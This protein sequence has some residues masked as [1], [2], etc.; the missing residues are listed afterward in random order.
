MPP[1]RN[2]DMMKEQRWR[3]TFAKWEASGLTIVEFCRLN[4]VSYRDFT[5]WR[6]IIRER[7]LEPGAPMK[8]YSRE[9]K[10]S[11]VN[12]Q[13]QSPSSQEVA[14]MSRAQ[15]GR[16]PPTQIEFAEIKV[17]EGRMHS[18]HSEDEALEIVMP[19]G[20]ILRAKPFCCLEFLSA[21]ISALEKR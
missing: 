5:N 9:K 16:L 15:R 8:N 18:R 14:Q 13:Q 1:L 17:V 4:A 7:D 10:K 20:I 11:R 6:R 12:N 19:G 2:R 3:A 21:V